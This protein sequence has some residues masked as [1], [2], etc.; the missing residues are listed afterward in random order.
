MASYHNT[1]QRHNTE[2]LD[3]NLIT[4]LQLQMRAYK[5]MWS[6]DSTTVR[7]IELQKAIDI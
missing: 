3:V 5:V 6:C 1:S 7:L 4:C 2:D